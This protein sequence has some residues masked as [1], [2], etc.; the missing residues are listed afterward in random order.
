MGSAC[1]ERFV[2]MFAFAICDTQSNEDCVRDQYG[3][4]P[5][6]YTRVSDVV[7]F[8]SRSNADV[9]RRDPRIDHQALNEWFLYRN[10]DALMPRTLV[11]GISAVL[12]GQVVEISRNGI[13]S[14]LYYSPVSHVSQTEYERF[15]AASPK[16]VV[17][18]VDETLNDAVRLRL[19]S[20][21]PVGTLLSGGLDSSL[22][23]A[24]ASKY[25]HDLTA[26]HVSVEGYP[27]LDER[28]YAEQLAT[29]LELK[30][31]PYALT[32]AAFRKAFP[33]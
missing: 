28:R 4:K 8:A 20:D 14:S 24:I 33:T 12:P 21:V 5:L 31:V 25:T 23:T 26:F 30:F 22:I 3:K 11:E 1:L 18:E 17:D 10:V 2:G 15:A 29:S 7:L 6:Y 19:I 32:G 27:N 13:K 9:D 16:Q